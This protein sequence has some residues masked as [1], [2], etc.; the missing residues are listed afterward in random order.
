M[1]AAT[2]IRQ[3][4]LKSDLLAMNDVA[5]DRS[6]EESEEGPWGKLT[7]KWKANSCNITV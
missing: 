5:H 3:S 7:L 2:E 4:N 6:R 1:Q